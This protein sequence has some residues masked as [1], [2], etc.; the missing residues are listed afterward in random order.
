MS[1]VQCTIYARAGRG[2]DLVAQADSNQSGN[3]ENGEKLEV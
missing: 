2:L 3:G 1:G